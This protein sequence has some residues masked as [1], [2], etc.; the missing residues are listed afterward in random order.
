MATKARTKARSATTT[1]VRSAVMSCKDAAAA[2]NITKSTLQY[3]IRHGRI[4]RATIPGAKKSLGVIAADIEKIL[5][6]TKN[7]GAK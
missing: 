1:S 7:G 3:H 4:R 2:L 5:S 6:P